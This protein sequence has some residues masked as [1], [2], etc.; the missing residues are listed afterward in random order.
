MITGL[1]EIIQ[2]QKKTIIF[3][4]TE[5]ESRQEI[6]SASIKFDFYLELIDNYSEEIIVISK[7]DS[8]NAIFEVAINK[9]ITIDFVA[10][11]ALMNKDFDVSIFENKV[12][13]FNKCFDGMTSITNNTFINVDKIAK[14]S[15]KF[16]GIDTIGEGFLYVSYFPTLLKLLEIDFNF[17]YNNID[18]KILDKLLLD[19][20]IIMKGNSFL[21][22]ININYWYDFNNSGNQNQNVVKFGL[23]GF[24][25][26]DQIRNQ[27]LNLKQEGSQLKNKILKATI[28]EE[29]AKYISKY[30]DTT[31]AI[32]ATRSKKLNLFLLL[33]CILLCIAF[34]P[35]SVIFIIYFFYRK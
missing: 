17:D 21:S 23:D 12:I 34:P 11:G 13:L 5:F 10:T 20:F 1:K 15:K 24:D 6:S 18:K 3:E 33:F 7:S 4:D 27:A 8:R 14:I 9:N 35:I 16:I 25:V 30:V 22:S 31:T 32:K 28:P 2:A 29:Q 19:N 26:S